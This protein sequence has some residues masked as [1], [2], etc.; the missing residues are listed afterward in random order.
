M[1]QPLA[2]ELLVRAPVA[3]PAGKSQA[4]RRQRSAGV[5]HGAHGEVSVTV[6]AGG[7][8]ALVPEL[9]QRAVGRAPVGRQFVTVA[10]PAVL[11][12]RLGLRGRTEAGQ[13]A[14]RGARPGGGMTVD[15]GGPVSGTRE[16]RRAVDAVGI[17][18]GGG[19]VAAYAH[20]RSPGL[21]VGEPGGC[22]LSAGARQTIRV[23]GNTAQQ[24]VSG[25][26]KGAGIHVQRQGAAIGEARLTG[27]VAVAGE[28]E[29]VVPSRLLGYRPGPAIRLH[30][31]GTQPR[32]G[33]PRYI[34]PARRRLALLAG[35]G[36]PGK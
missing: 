26:A 12:H 30:P 4:G 20:L 11:G 7:G 14:R 18:A 10:S 36:R 6:G 28:A 17:V 34:W 32:A 31:E 35:A 1:T 3:L 22:H 25:I 9:D 24:P 19:Q 29:G 15:A 16:H 2:G 27:G 23:T 8:P 5:V 33:R 13:T 21:V